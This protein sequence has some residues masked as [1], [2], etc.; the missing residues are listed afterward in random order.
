MVSHE[1]RN[2]LNAMLQCAEETSQL[3]EK[4]RD[5]IKIDTETSTIFNDLEDMINTLLYCGAHQKQLID[6]V[7]TL[8]KLDSKLLTIYPAKVY[9]KILLDQAI[10][11]FSSEIRASEIQV[12]TSLNDSV[13]G[14]E[15]VETPAIMVDSNRIMQILINLIS[16]AVK[17]TR[18]REKRELHINVH[19]SQER[20]S[21]G[22]LNYVSSGHQRADPT[23]KVEWGNG[24]PIY[25]YYSVRDTGPGLTEQEMTSLFTRFKQASP[26]T[27]VTYGGS[28]LGL[29]ISRELTELH[30]GEIGMTSGVD[31]GST[32][33]FY[34]KGRRHLPRRES[35]RSSSSPR[36]VPQQDREIYTVGRTKPGTIPVSV[37]HS[38]PQPDPPP[39]LHVLVVEDNDINRRVLKR[40]LE[41]L[42]YQVT[43]AIHGAEALA[44]VKTSTWWRGDRTKEDT[45]L[46]EAYDARPRLSVILCDL[47]MPVMDGITC[48]RQ[49]RQWQQEGLLHDNVPV[50][51]VT[52]NARAETTLLATQSDFDHV[53]SKPY[54]FKTLVE[55]ILAHVDQAVENTD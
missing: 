20:Q 50:I 55:Q 36:P 8:S 53:V 33:G 32:F 6:D 45:Q 25:L 37:F 7:L 4:L 11:V 46:L 5:R 51:A 31:V 35:L 14:S 41:K 19:I 54:S 2:P 24:E 28:G 52:G 47:E 23:M 30:G 40:Q 38:P 10:K 12:F 17:F 3:I 22:A 48:V 9:P 43:T 44:V 13:R 18:E 42:G 39:P 27:H 1:M 15:E 49:I 29:F 34:V 21:I 16:N 26:R